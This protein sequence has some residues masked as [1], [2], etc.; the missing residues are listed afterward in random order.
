LELRPIIASATGNQ[1]KVTEDF[2]MVRQTAAKYI[3]EHEDEF[4]AFLEEP[5]E[6][7][8]S[9]VRNTGEWGGQLELLALAKAYNVD[10]SV[11]QGDGGTVNVEGDGPAHSRKKLFLA[12]YKH[13][14]GLGEHYNSLRKQT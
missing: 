11:L 7:Y 5:L 8:V 3:E 10:I 1:D 2:K 6:D 4:I 12:Y 14:F 9:K 13:N